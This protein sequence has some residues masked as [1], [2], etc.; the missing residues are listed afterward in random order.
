FAARRG[1]RFRLP[2]VLLLLAS[3]LTAQSEPYFQT[4]FPAE[5]FQ[6]RWAKILD[7][8]G[9][10]AF[11]I[12]QG[13]PKVAGFIF[14]RQT[15]EF[16][17]LCGVETPG[18]YLVLDGKTR[19]AILFLP[20]R[21][22]RLERSEGRVLSAAD[23]DLAKKLTGASEVLSTEAVSVAWLQRTGRVIYTPHAPAEGYAQSR[24]EIVSAN[25]AIASDY[26]DGRVSR[27]TNFIGLL[28]TRL[29]RAEIRDLTPILDELRILKS[30]REAALVRRASQIAGLGLLEAMK[31]TRPGLYEYHLDAAARYVFLIHGAR[32]DGYRSITAAGTPNINNMHYYR[33]NG[34]LRD[35]DLVLMD[36][37]PD[38]RYYVSD[39]GR[40]WPV[41]GKYSP[42]QRELLQFVLEYRNA[43]LK[44]IRPGVR[45]DQIM[46]EA[47]AAMEPVFARTKFSKP[48]YEKAARTLVNTGGGVFSHSVGM[49]V[50][51]VGTYRRDALKPGHVFS[52]DPQ[53]WVREE[54]LYLRYEDVVV[55]TGMGFENFTSFLPSELDDIEKTVRGEGIV[56]KFPPSPEAVR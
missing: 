13:Y 50:H 24:G 28:R 3:T 37:A 21:D 51:D 35:G 55:V 18:S 4:D 30:P 9:S 33:N 31:T 29:P 32:L 41:N 12:V 53:M 42:V 43:I 38:Y 40:V 8:I 54:S 2:T 11:A 52:V 19:R 22:E 46:E 5:E 49:A 20:P 44:R 15:N 56:Q 26:W 1:R 47:K 6:A 48:I 17:Y 34:P 45:A 25:E 23:A 10:N 27:E 36:Y 39:I 7:K 16:Y 14:P